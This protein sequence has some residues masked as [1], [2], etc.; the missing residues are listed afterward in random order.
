MHNFHIG[1]TCLALPRVNSPVINSKGI[2][3]KTKVRMKGAY[4]PSGQPQSLY[5][6]SSHSTYPGW[7]KGIEVILQEC[8][9][10]ASHLN[11]TCKAFKYPK[12]ATFYC[13]KKNSLLI[14]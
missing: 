8:S 6:D 5:F 13:Q 11:G 4:L 3:V 1:T 12:G 14:T 7:F 2:V 9:I 10:D